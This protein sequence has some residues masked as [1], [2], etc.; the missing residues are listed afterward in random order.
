MNNDDFVE[1][2]EELDNQTQLLMD[3]YPQRDIAFTKYILDEICELTDTQDYNLAVGVRKDS[4][5]R[6]QG[7]LYAWN[8]SPNGEILTLFYTLYD[9]S[10]DGVVKT[11]TDAEFQS[12]LNKLQGFYTYSLRGIHLD[13]E[14]DQ[15]TD[16][17][18][19]EPAKYIYENIKEITTVRLCVI[20][21]CTINK[22]EIKNIRINGKAVFPDVW[23]LKKIYSNLHSAVDHKVIDVDFQAEGYKNFK[24]P[25]LEME[26]DKFG[27]KCI[28]CMFP[29]KLL[30][31]LYEQHNTDLLLNNV[32][33]FLG[34]KGKQKTNA[35]VGIL[36][37]LR[38]ESQMFLAYNNGI[39]ALASSVDVNP[40][41]IRQDVS[42]LDE[43][44][45]VKNNDFISVG[46]LKKIHDF[47]IVNGGQTTASIFHG[48]YRDQS[49]SLYGVYIQVKI[50]ILTKDVN[51]I[52]SKV[53]L[54]SNSQNKIKYA[55]FSVS[56]A[57]NSELEKLSRTVK[58]P[59]KNN[60]S[61]FWYF[62]RVRGQYDE[63]LKK[64]TTKASQQYF[65]SQ[66]PKDLRFKKEEMAKVWKSWKQEPYD[67]VKGE[68]TNYSMFN[69][70][71]VKTG[72]IPDEQYY[73]DSIAL[74][75]IYRFLMRRP[76]NKTY[77][78][79]KATIATYALAY[80]N[81][82]SFNKLD[83]DKIWKNQCLSD[84]LK[85]YLNKLCEELNDI[86]IILA[87]EQSVLS[88]GKRKSSYNEVVNYG[89]KLDNS[90]L[91]NDKIK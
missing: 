50:I 36:N 68:A 2:L 7:A 86:L 58:I 75:I 67:A 56:N 52:V 73:K 57:F 16:N 91:H 76:E 84:N 34:F 8:I 49:I 4:G 22:Y 19:Y 11:L 71:N 43:D 30:Y 14:D 69:D 33:Y 89:I 3:E 64:I 41:G 46:M 23:D 81:Y 78:N 5:G 44:G 24:I 12:A 17:P 28:L 87:G 13:M 15:D 51:E 35:N 1:Y 48:K 74:L 31:K 20:S 29:A 61:K 66:Y 6:T 88:Y 62:E 80:L 54:Y 77:G 60:D 82:A 42:D 83:L 90:L 27:Y 26:S 72:F 9:S 38:E 10:S 21:N 47:R 45:G 53:T 65:Y 18:L 63:E 39:T 85:I 59:N 37:T 40:L 79:R 70:N 55:D 32:R 25:F